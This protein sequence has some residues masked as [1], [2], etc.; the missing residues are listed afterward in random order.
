[1]Q[2]Q[3][4]RFLKFGHV[5]PFLMPQQPKFSMEFKSLNSFESGP[6]KEHS[7]EV[8]MQLVLWFRRR[9]CLK[10]KVNDDG[11][12]AAIYSHIR[13]NSPGLRLLINMAWRNLIVGQPR[14]ISTKL[15]EKQAWHFLRRKIFFSFHYSH[16]RQKSP[17]LLAA[18]IFDFD[19]ST[20]LEGI[21]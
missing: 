4:R 11:Q 19:Q 6:P 7:C 16:I 18:M 8:W 5:A 14:N 2:I 10:L 15:F 9:W 20:W 1:M 3:R 17:N 12:R 13:P 21:W